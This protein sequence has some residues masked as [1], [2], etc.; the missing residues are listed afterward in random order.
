[1]KHLFKLL[2]F[3]TLVFYVSC[4]DEE[5]DT[6]VDTNI[7]TEIDSIKPKGVTSDMET[8]PI[9]Q[10][11]NKYIPVNI[12]V[13]GEPNS[14]LATRRKSNRVQLDGEDSGSGREKWYI[15]IYPRGT[16]LQVAGGYYKGRRNLCMGNPQESA[17]TVTGDGNLYN[18]NCYFNLDFENIPNTDRYYIR[19]GKWATNRSDVYLTSVNGF[20][21]FK[22]KGNGGQQWVI[23]PIEE[24]EVIDINYQFLSTD[25]LNITPKVISI[26]TV[27]NYYANPATKT[28]QF[29]ETIEN[30]SEFSETQGLSI[31]RK[32]SNSL[33]VN[34][35]TLLN[36][37]VDIETTTGQTWSYNTGKKE[38]KTIVLTETLTQVINPNSSLTAKLVAVTYEADITYIAT[39]R[40]TYNPSH[41][42]YLKGRWQGLQ[43]NDAT[44]DLYDSNQIRIK[45]IPVNID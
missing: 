26:K 1:M 24:F 7:K 36:G 21:D 2:F 38:R 42:L 6:I 9:G 32:A 11:V 19:I 28:I 35:P 17:C 14:Y 29:S 33:N 39:L 20:V 22:N 30:T 8:D 25:R 13:Y 4:Q 27:N 10:L 43:V 45:S 23:S 41:I 44:V 31:T 16:Y 37:K 18:S 34:V 12:T 5:L 40:S 15:N 3:I